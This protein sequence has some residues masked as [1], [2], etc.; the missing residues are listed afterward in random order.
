MSL[1]LIFYIAAIVLGLGLLIRRLIKAQ[2]RSPVN[3]CTVPRGD[4]SQIP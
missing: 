3:D 2:F 1:R 4:Q